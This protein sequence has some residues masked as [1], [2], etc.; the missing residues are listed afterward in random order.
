MSVLRSKLRKDLAALGG[1]FLVREQSLRLQR[2][3]TFQALVNRERVLLR[4]LRRE[5]RRIVARHAGRT[6]ADRSFP[7][8][9][10]PCPFPVPLTASFRC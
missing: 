4:L 7:V 8:E 10:F 9:G 2:V 6:D 5:V 1:V 3:E